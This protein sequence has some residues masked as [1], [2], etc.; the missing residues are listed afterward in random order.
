MV[1]NTAEPRS[2]AAVAE[3]TIWREIRVSA[4]DGLQLHARDY[5][6]LD[7]ERLPVVC[8]PGLSR[9]CRD[10]HDLAIFLSSHKSKPRRVVSMD[11]RGRG[12]SG[13]DGDWRR[14]APLVELGDVL[15]L[16]V[17]ARID[18]ACFVG[19]SRGGIVTMLL[20]AVRPTAIAAAI[21][22]DVGPEIDG[23]G[24]LRIKNMLAAARSP[25]TWEEAVNLLRDAYQGH[26]PGI[27]QEGWEDFARKTFDDRDGRPV[28][29][30][31]PKLMKTLE[32]VDYNQPLPTMW[33]Q[34][35]GLA[36]APVMVIRGANS[37]ILAADTLA[38]MRER[39]PDLKVLEVADA[40]HAPMLVAQDELV[41]IAAFVAAADDR[42]R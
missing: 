13:W 25:R 15:D 30:F 5:G 39:R 42:I 10:F 38:R 19:T 26:F 24:L 36:N 41:A 40:G 11:F 31:D 3:A 37:D 22:N 35:E 20:G 2:V 18:R 7:S 6:P 21:L 23:R 27:G 9:N 29:A 4:G 34:F 16:L 17:A 33:P 12:G 8:L 14:Y 32:A 28:R 1:A